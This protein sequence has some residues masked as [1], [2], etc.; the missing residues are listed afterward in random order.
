MA[1]IQPRSFGD[2][3]RRYRVSTGLT[4]EE[5]AERSGLSRRAIGSLETGE[6][7]TP[8]RETVA[9]LAQALGLTSAEHALLESAA[10]Q[11]LPSTTTQTYLVGGVAAQWPGSGRSNLPLAGRQQELTALDRHL[12][13][14]GPPLLVL[15]GEAGI[16]KSRLLEESV[17]RGAEQ[18]WT[19]LAGGC[20]RRNGQEP[21]APFI[22]ALTRFLAARSPAQQRLDLQG[23]AWIVRLLPELAELG[24][25][26][27]TSWTLPPEQER[28][29]LFS[30]VRRFLTNV[31]GP[32]GTLV[33]LDDLHWAGAES[34]D[35]LAALLQETAPQP[36]QIVAAYRDTDVA[37]G[38][39]LPLLLGDLTR[40]GLATRI[41]LSPLE[42]EPA[43]DLLRSLLA[44]EPAGPGEA[45]FSGAS[46]TV[47]ET[48][49]DR[50]GG[51]PYFLVSWAQE[52]RTATLT[53][54]T[55]RTMVPWSAAESIRQRM[56]VLPE[57]AFHLLAVAA[58]AGRQVARK[59]LL[60]AA[61]EAS[62]ENE[63]EILAALD[64]ICSA[65]LL[66]EVADGSYTFPHDLIRETVV[67]D[68]GGARRA[69]LHCRV[70]T[71]LEV[72]PQAERQAAEL[73]WHFVAGDEP[74]RALPYALQAGEQAEEVFAHTEAERHYRMAVELARAC[75]ELPREARA[76]E[77][78]ADVLVGM[79]NFREMLALL[80][81]AAAIHRQAG[82]MD[83]FAWDVAQATRPYTL[84]G[85]SDVAFARLQELLVSLAGV[86][87][88]LS[89]PLPNSLESLA[90]RA[91]TQLSARTA[92]RIYLS[93]AAC[94]FYQQSYLQVVPFG[95][96]AVRY[97]ESARER[98][99]EVRARMF[100]ANALE[101]LGQLAQARAV[102]QAGFHVAQAAGDLEGVSLMAGS[103]GTLLIESGA[104]AEGARAYEQALDAARTFGG[105][106]TLVQ[107]HIGLARVALYRG[108][109]DETLFSCE[110]ALAV[111]AEHDFERYSADVVLLQG[112]VSLYRGE[113]RIALDS[114]NQVIQN[115]TNATDPTKVVLQAHTALSEA[116]LLDGEASAARARLEPWLERSGPQER[117]STTLLPFLAWAWSDRGEV[118][119]AEALLAECLEKTREQH[120]DLVVVDALR[121]QAMLALHRGHW[122]EAKQALE[123]ALSLCRA[124]P[125][126]YVEAKALHVYGQI[127]AASGE[128]EHA[129]ANFQ[130]GL[131]ILHQLGERLYAKH[132]ERALAHLT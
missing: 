112:L 83:Q 36:L 127:D 46:V 28:R 62:G 89:N 51:L 65:R 57:G 120:Y 66:R 64:A 38:E 98:W 18:G 1:S 117:F 100:L 12:G 79:G 24:I 69:A 81:A 48:V 21:Y 92:S 102:N 72:Q 37:A 60:T 30:A 113:R 90:A 15:A 86:A 95:E 32:A 78:L 9:L 5:L 44:S 101:K 50:S 84:L 88:P 107:L 58:V 39:L 34:V 121:V 14:A 103:L 35:L 2:L 87:G 13:H 71:A 25:S 110:R 49:L 124:I 97:S 23:C 104:L 126:P 63:A 26:P 3:L 108:A 99:I 43:R 77:Q 74:A 45:D 42:R 31:A 130:A 40:E 8:H 47:M 132:L 67:A 70:A 76:L 6:R 7:L 131:A 106:D 91:V 56:A 96:H 52:A 80:D 122:K 27:A 116:E 61:A 41:S 4:Q 123:E 105:P 59:V 68:L 82:N 93:I 29:L 118:E 11:R 85:Q 22:T 55:A 128:K 54:D 109:W 17:R 19:V 16:G 10:R 111:M 125:Y 75:G 129:Y 73:A 94:L 53:S 114:L 33:V 115:N 20:H 119:R